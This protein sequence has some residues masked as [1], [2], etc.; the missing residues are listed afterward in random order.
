LYQ[1]FDLIEITIN[2][3]HNDIRESYQLF[4][5]KCNKLRKR[6][7][8]SL[9]IHKYVDIIHSMLGINSRSHLLY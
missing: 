4:N 8:L 7:N 5:L 3:I 1:R 9:K 2:Q 6:F